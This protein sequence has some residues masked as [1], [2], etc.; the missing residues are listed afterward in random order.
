MQTTGLVLGMDEVGRGCWAGPVVVGAVLLGGPITG[1]RDSKQLSVKSR[2]KF[3]EL[4]CSQSV[5]YGI[6][7]ASSQEVD[8]LGLT[9][10]LTLAYKRALALIS[11]PYDE[12]VIDGNYNFLMNA[13][14]VRT[15]VKA[16]ALVAAVSAASILAKV[17]RDRLMLEQDKS[18]PGYGFARHVGYGTAEHIRALQKLGVCDIHRR[19]FAPI[20]RQLEVSA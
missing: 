6:G 20:R 17:T 12:I 8:A 15:L 2:E 16:D 14:K 19:S 13:P 4:I 3:A 9:A 11:T 10:A 5:S 1:L 7:Q 18:Y